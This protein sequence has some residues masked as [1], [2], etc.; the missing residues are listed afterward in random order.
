MFVIFITDKADLRVFTVFTSAVENYHWAPFA[1]NIG[2]CGSMKFDLIAQLETAQEHIID[3]KERVI[4][5]YLVSTLLQFISYELKMKE[6]QCCSLISEI[7]L[8]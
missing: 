1:D 5:L 2:L 6:S 7:N 4:L 8:F 3:M